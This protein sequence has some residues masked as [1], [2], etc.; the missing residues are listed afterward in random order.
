MILVIV[1]QIKRQNP[2]NVDCLRMSSFLLVYDFKGLF[3]STLVTNLD[4][5]FFL[6]QYIV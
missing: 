3:D 6:Q 4:F 2:Q 1:Q 5:H